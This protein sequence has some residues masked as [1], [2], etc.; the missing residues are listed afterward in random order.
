[1]MMIS[2][3]RCDPDLLTAS[4]DYDLPA[5]LIA[6]EPL[7]RRDDSRLLVLCGDQPPVHRHFRDLTDY[8]HQGDLLVLN[9]TR[10]LP[11]RLFGV[12]ERTGAVVECF[13]LRKTADEGM[14]WEILS[15]PA[16][17]C[18]VGDRFL[19]GDHLLIGTVTAELERGRRKMSFE[20]DEP[21]DRVIDQLGRVPLPPYI[22]RE[23]DDP[24]RYQTVYAISRGS[25]AAPTAGL[26]FTVDL[27]TR[28]KAQGVRVQ[29][30]TLHVGLGTFLPVKEDRIEDHL[31]HTEPY[32]IPEATAEA[33]C[34]TK[35]AGGRVIAV[36]TTSCRV[37][38]G[39][40]KRRKLTDPAR[41]NLAT[42]FTETDLFIYPGFDFR[43][44]DGL[45]T[46]FHLPKSTLLM[47]VSALMG[48][49]TILAAYREAVRERYRFFSF[50]DAMLLLPKG[51]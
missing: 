51:D 43:V 44:I 33:V 3:D 45:I 39:E 1:M 6:E 9:D 10:V 4:Y 21:F 32:T 28:L 16:R 36:G 31:M 2:N 42:D 17:R 24:E 37:L 22:H 48:R 40:A 7:S 34:E 19:F 14:V 25:V 41:E 20:S 5:E 46:N 13:L 35:R 38:E 29:S 26:H 50:G 27:L 49:E 15:K 18:R 23:L 30:V 12:R 8:L 11:A 47:L